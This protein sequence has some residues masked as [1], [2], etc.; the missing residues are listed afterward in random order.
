MSQHN[1]AFA[2]K[3]AQSAWL[4]DGGGGVNRNAQIGL[5]WVFPK[6]V[7]RFL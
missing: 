5:R 6:S 7:G 4:S 2:E 1:W 3:V